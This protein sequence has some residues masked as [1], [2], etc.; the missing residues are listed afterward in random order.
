MFLLTM[1]LATHSALPSGLRG[2]RKSC[3]AY[4]TIDQLVERAANIFSPG[5]SRKPLKS[6]DSDMEIQENQKAF[7]WHFAP[8]EGPSRAQKAPTKVCKM[9]IRNVLLETSNGSA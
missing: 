9:R 2:R 6:L 1:D 3:G 4:R 5:G 7:L 8:P